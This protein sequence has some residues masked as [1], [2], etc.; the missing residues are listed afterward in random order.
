ME[1]KEMSFARM[2][3]WVGKVL[4]EWLMERDGVMAW[5]NKHLREL[6]YILIFIHLF[7]KM[8]AHCV[9]D[10]VSGAPFSLTLSISR[11]IY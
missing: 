2:G 8:S 5:I 10:I 6:L 11:I 7:D 3:T 1:L 4:V 9:P